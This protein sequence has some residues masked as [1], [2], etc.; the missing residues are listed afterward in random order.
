MN[1]LEEV[2]ERIDILFQVGAFCIGMLFALTGLV[3]DTV[4]G[5]GWRVFSDY[6]K[7]LCCHLDSNFPVPVF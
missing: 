1:D 7:C 2:K 3:C 6:S 5:G 4:R